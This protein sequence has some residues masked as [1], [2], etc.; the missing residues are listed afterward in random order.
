MKKVAIFGTYPPPIGGTSIHIKRLRDLLRKKFDVTV[1]N[2]FF[3]SINKE[4]GVVNVENKKKWYLK[5]FFNIQEDI[6]SCHSHS[7]VERFILVLVAKIRNKKIIIT[8]HSLRKDIKSESFI[9][10]KLASFVL[11]FASNHISINDNIKLKLLEFGTDNEKIIN[12]PTFLLPNYIDNELDNDEII[13][14]IS[15]SS[16]TICSNASNNNK[17]LGV[18]LYGFDLCVNTF[19]KV[20][21]FKENAKFIY[22][23][24]RITDF[25][26]YEEMKET[27]KRYNLENKFY[28]F[29][30]SL[31]YSSLL[32]NCDLSIRATCSDTYG[33]SVGE[34]I[35]LNTPCIASD[36]CPRTE[37]AILFKNRSEDELYRSIV[38]VISEKEK[39]KEILKLINVK[40]YSQE[41]LDFFLKK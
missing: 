20:V 32:L 41:T 1:Y 39:E 24:T 4:K 13:K 12:L 3:G 33:L 2:T 35:H 36:V 29:V 38:R 25:T 7:W 27:I 23:L 31:D 6:I 19:R 16:F 26:Y 21:E 18:D 37:G 11:K 28:L 8:Y 22:I 14:V 34:S 10:Q 5:Y 40:D 9:T 30:T 17:H 15:T